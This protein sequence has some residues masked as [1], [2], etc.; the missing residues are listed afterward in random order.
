MNR[1]GE[2]SAANAVTCRNRAF[3]SSRAVRQLVALQTADCSDPTSGDN[4]TVSAARRCKRSP[5]RQCRARHVAMNEDRSRRPWLPWVSLVCGLAGCSD[6]TPSEMAATRDA[7]SR[8]ADA[9]IPQSDAGEDPVEAT[10]PDASSDSKGSVGEP[11]EVQA[12]AACD[13]PSSTSYAEVEPII[14][15]RCL[16]CHDGSTEQWP[17]TSYSHVASWYDEI[18]GMMLTCSM[19]PPDSGLSMTVSERQALLRWIRC[20]LPR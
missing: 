16:E 19:P 8:P 6:T 17:L 14:E 20:G 18:R 1:H 3:R 12:P 2:W 5:R 13:D 4:C 11:C 15:R 7:S 9:A 10:I